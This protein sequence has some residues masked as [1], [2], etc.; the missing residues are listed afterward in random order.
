MQIYKGAV[1]T[2]LLTFEAV[3]IKCLE[4]TKRDKIKDNDQ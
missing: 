1:D 2:F 3:N 4:S